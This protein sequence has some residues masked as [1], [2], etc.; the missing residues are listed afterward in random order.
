MPALLRLNP[1]SASRGGGNHFDPTLPALDLLDRAP[2]R[3]DRTPDQ[4]SKNS[5][6]PLCA[7][8]FF[9]RYTTGRLSFTL[10]RDRD[11][12]PAPAFYWGIWFRRAVEGNFSPC[13][14]FGA[15]AEPARALRPPRVVSSRG[16]VRPRSRCPLR[17]DAPMASM[18][19]VR[20]SRSSPGRS[21]RQELATPWTPSHATPR[22]LTASLAPWL[23]LMPRRG[24]LGALGRGP[25]PQARRGHDSRCGRACLL[26]DEHPRPCI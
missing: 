25:L 2:S 4:K 26:V 5:I 20:T 3:F 21:S 22:A 15:G 19:Q 17:A 23:Q 16:R 18:E 13:G 14:D 8:F 1:V 10:P 7:S 12:C 24:I 6:P 11:P 9:V